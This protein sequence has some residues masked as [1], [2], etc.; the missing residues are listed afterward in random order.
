M[1]TTA[2]MRAHECTSTHT[3]G[4]LEG[5]GGSSGQRASEGSNPADLQDSNSLEHRRLVS[6][7]GQATM[8]FPEGCPGL[9]SGAG[10]PTPPFPAPGS[11]ACSSFA[12]SLGLPLMML[13]N[14]AVMLLLLLPLGSSLRLTVSP[15]IPKDTQPSGTRARPGLGRTGPNL[16]AGAAEGLWHAS[17][18]IAYI[19]GEGEEG[20]QPLRHCFGL[21][22]SAP[23]LAHSLTLDSGGTSQGWPQAP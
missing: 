17:Q 22:G 2:L 8:T 9:S 4:I 10:L 6:T 5:S 14:E 23:G 12:S 7:E 21:S 18:N 3:A 20:R 16:S 13:H 15:F 1:R 19:P 11:F